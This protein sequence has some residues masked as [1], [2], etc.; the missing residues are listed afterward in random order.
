M[1]DKWTGSAE[2]CHLFINAVRAALKKPPMPWSSRAEGG[3]I[4]CNMRYGRRDGREA[5]AYGGLQ[6]FGRSGGR[7]ILPG[8]FHDVEPL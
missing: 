3:G 2:Q 7:K 8:A 4:P 1:I 6:I 5:N